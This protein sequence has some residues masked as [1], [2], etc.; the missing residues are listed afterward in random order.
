[1]NLLAA[2][3]IKCFFSNKIVGCAQCDEQRSGRFFLVQLVESVKCRELRV[4]VLLVGYQ[5]TVK[6]LFQI[7]EVFL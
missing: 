1:M 4:I 7:I 3:Q 2:Q 6:G 5:R